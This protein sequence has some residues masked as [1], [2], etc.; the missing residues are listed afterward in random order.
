MRGSEAARRIAALHDRLEDLLGGL[1]AL[2]AAVLVLLV[3]G[4]VAL[5]YGF[6]MGSVALQELGQ[7]LHA[8]IFML[9]AG[10]ALRRDRHVRVDLLYGRLGARARLRL[11]AFACLGVVLPFSVFAFAVSLDYVTASFAIGEGSREPGGLPALWLVKGLIPA[12]A[13]LLGLRAV[14]QGLRALAALRR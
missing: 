3:A 1:L 2:L 7:H 10:L 12:F 5:R 14:A 6:G 9:G 4:V 13:V 8:A 11:D